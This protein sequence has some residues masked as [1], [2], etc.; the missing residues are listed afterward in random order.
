MY[1]KN[2]KV[3]FGILIILFLIALGFIMPML[4]RVSPAVAK[5][6]RIMNLQRWHERIRLYEDKKGRLPDSLYEAYY[7]FNVRY[8][9]MLTNPDN[10]DK[11]NNEIYFNDPNAFCA[12]IDYIFEKYVSDWV[13]KES[14]IYKDSTYLYIDSSGMVHESK[15]EIQQK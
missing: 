13:V 10:R 15:S 11:I 4:G 3:I 8:S 5:K 7:G 9:S 14:K 2:R 1:L 12:T 6:M